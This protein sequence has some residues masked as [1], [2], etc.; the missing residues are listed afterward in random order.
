MR[1]VAYTVRLRGFDAEKALGMLA[2]QVHKE[3]L[4][5]GQTGWTEN[6]VTQ[7][8]YDWVRP[9]Q[10]NP[11]RLIFTLLAESINLLWE[12][13]FGYNSPSTNF[14]DKSDGTTPWS[15]HW[16]MTWL[17]F[18]RPPGQEKGDIMSPRDLYQPDGHE[19]TVPIDGRPLK[20]EE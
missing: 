8:R 9:M 1:E 20:V 3:A 16:P 13:I 19:R 5:L 17:P 6:E 11:F 14:L 10:R 15:R 7:Y 2:E 18:R 12:C 4:A